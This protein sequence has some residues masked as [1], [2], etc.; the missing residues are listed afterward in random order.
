[1]FQHYLVCFFANRIT[2]ILTSKVLWT[3]PP[4]IPKH[5]CEFR[6]GI[7]AAHVDGADAALSGPYWL[8][9]Q[10]SAAYYFAY[11]PQTR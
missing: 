11:S 7:G 6:P 2:F 8:V 9:S 10:H 4:W 1:M 3:D 5:P